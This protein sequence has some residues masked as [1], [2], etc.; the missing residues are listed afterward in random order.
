M[1]QKVSKIKAR[2]IVTGCARDVSKRTKKAAAHVG[3][4]R[5]IKGHPR[6][7]SF[8]WSSRLEKALS[9]SR[10]PRDPALFRSAPPS[11]R[12]GVSS[13]RAVT[14]ELTRGRTC[15]RH[16]AIARERAI[17]VCLRPSAWR[18]GRRYPLVPPQRATTWSL[19]SRS[20]TSLRP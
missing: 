14:T 15:G 10:V 18:G 16:A 9:V 11:R 13:A 4:R 8:C 6:K 1:E 20:S 19:G 17:R 5:V 3:E 2:A 7:S 12:A